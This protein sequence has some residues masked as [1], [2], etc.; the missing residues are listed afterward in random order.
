MEEEHHVYK[1]RIVFQGNN[2]RDQDGR[3]AKFEE[4]S[5]APA[6]MEAGKVGGPMAL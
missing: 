2:A 3:A 5:S 6:S 1:R 4:M